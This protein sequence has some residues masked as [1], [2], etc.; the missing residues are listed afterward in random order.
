MSHRLSV[1]RL[2]S[3]KSF[4]AAEGHPYGAKVIGD[5]G[6]L[7]LQFRKRYMGWWQ[8]TIAALL[9]E[10]PE[11][12]ALHILVVGHGAF[13]RSMFQALITDQSYEIDSSSVGEKLGIMPNTGI[14]VV[15]V[16]EVH[17]GRLVVWGEESHLKSFGGENLE[18]KVLFDNVD[19]LAP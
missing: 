18:V 12:T 16:D 3:I 17:V 13:I 7:P 14:T 5:K 19:D 9:E 11:D 8:D 2:I 1:N 15:E 10:S 4:G 6:E